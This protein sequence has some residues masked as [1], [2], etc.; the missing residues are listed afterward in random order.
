MIRKVTERHPSKKH[1]KS[2]V[3]HWAASK[4]GRTIATA[5]TPGQLVKILSNLGS[6]AVG[7]VARYVGPDANNGAR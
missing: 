2:P 5:E 1:P 4:A 6:A 3:G 7:S